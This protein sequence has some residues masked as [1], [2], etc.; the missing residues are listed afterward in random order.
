VERVTYHAKDSGYTLAR[1]KVASHHDLIT[2]VG[3]FP[4]IHAGQTL[5]LTG[6]YREH[7]TYGQKSVSETTPSPETDLCTL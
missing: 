4:D 7:A 5:G 2:I 6:Y 1:L 3:S